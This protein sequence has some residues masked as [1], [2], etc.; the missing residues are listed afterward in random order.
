M[1]HIYA[2]ETAAQL[3]AYQSFASEIQVPLEQYIQWITSRFQLSS[4]PRTILWTSPKIATTLL[5]DIPIPAYTNDYR[6]VMTSELDAW[7]HIY[8]AQLADYLE[9]DTA[10]IRSYYKTNLNRHH[11]LQILGHELV[12]H[13][14]L[15]IDEVYESGEG[16]WFEEGM[17]EYISRRY[18]LTKAEFAEEAHINRLLVK[19]FESKERGTIPRD[20]DAFTY[21]QNLDAIFYEY[22][23]SFLAVD[24]IAEN[25]NG[26]ISAVFHSYHRWYEE[27]HTVPLARWFG[28]HL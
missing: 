8:L 6:I 9:A 27:G 24:Q 19:L 15:F 28:I 20:F 17:A 13:S 18:F 2:V 4:L 23:R 3:N 1:E 26:D 16:I 22:W 14:D 10:E 21:R 7:R 11:I 25:H 12:H 5:S